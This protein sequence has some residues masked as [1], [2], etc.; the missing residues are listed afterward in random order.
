MTTYAHIYT[1]QCRFDRHSLGYQEELRRWLTDENEFTHFVTLNL[2]RKHSPERAKHF[3]RLWFKNVLARL[4]RPAGLRARLPKD[5]LF[6]FAFPEDTLHDS[7]HFHLLT[8]VTP[9][10]F[11]YF[12]KLG[13]RLWINC[14]PSGTCDVQR[15][16][17]TQKDR[18]DVISYATKN[19]HRDYSRT[20]YFTSTE[21]DDA[22]KP[23]SPCRKRP[24]GARQ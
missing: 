22:P 4:M 1:D 18:D 10:C 21:F 6:F 9:E 15:I 13:C 23:L 11:D 8:R 3:V 7:P 17:S 24:Q 2:Y 12:E 14:V 5:V 19:V 16:G 20:G